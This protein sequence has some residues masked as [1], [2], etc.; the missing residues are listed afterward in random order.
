YFANGM[1]VRN[2]IIARGNLRGLKISNYISNNV[3]SSE[4]YPG[5]WVFPPMKGLYTSKLSI[6]ERIQKAKLGYEEYADWLTVT[7]ADVEHFKQFIEQHGPVCN[8]D[9]T[10]NDENTVDETNVD[11]T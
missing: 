6:N 4:K 2:L 9:E 3:V 7:P 11:E 10:N 1:K 5:G 8:D